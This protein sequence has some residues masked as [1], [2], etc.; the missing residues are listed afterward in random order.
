MS[1]DGEDHVGPNKGN[2]S[3]NPPTVEGTEASA[4]SN[5]PFRHPNSAQDTERAVDQTHKS[6]SHSKDKDGPRSTSPHVEKTRPENSSAQSA[7]K[8]SK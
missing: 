4:E 1:S 8:A 2:G 5:G 3:R 7:G 6:K